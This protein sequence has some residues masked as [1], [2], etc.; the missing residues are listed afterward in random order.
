MYKYFGQLCDEGCIWTSRNPEPYEYFAKRQAL[1]YSATV[2]DVMIQAGKNN[3][4]KNEDEWTVIAY[5][6]SEKKP[7]VLMNGPSYSI[8]ASTPEQQ[9]A[10]WIFIH[11][12]LKPENQTRIVMSSGSIP[13]SAAAVSQLSTFQQRYPA[14]QHSILW[15]PIAQPSP[16]GADWRV[17]R[18]VLEDSFWQYLQPQPTPQTRANPLPD[19]DETIKEILEQQKP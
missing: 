13:V 1:F 17:A 9:L 19:V 7:V 14:W 2:Q 11:W 5:P 16:R 6:V 10:S 12:M 18:G 8:A 3:Q 15:I 4:Y